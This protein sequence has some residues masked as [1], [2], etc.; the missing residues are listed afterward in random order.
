MKC[1]KCDQETLYSAYVRKEYPPEDGKRKRTNKAIGYVC[2]N[3]ACD[4][5]VKNAVE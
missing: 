3:P 1:P 2:V 4:Y 5:C